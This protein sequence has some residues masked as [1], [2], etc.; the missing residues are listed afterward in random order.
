MQPIIFLDLD[1]TLTVE[2]TWLSLNLALGITKEEDHAL[3]EQYLEKSLEYNAWTKKLIEIHRSRGS[4]TK[5][6]IIAMAQNL[7]LRDGAVEMVA[8]LK[9]KGF[10]TVLLTG[11]LDV[12]AETIAH[13]IDADAWRACS[14]FVFD[15]SET[16]VDINSN[17]E[18]INKKESLAKEYVAEHGFTEAEIYALGDGGND[19]ALFQNYKGILLGDNAKLAPIAWKHVQT[20]SEVTD[21]L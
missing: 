21:L 16:L 9:A 2:S 10:H 4:I 3:F 19:I 15:D 18:E 7:P 8:D 13:R 1:G 5:S 6:E 14:S 11:S 12:I 20:L 17:G